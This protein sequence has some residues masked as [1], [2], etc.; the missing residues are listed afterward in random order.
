[1]R[2]KRIAC[3]ACIGWP[4]KEPPPERSNDTISTLDL[5]SES[6]HGWL[7][8]RHIYLLDP[9]KEEPFH[10]CPKC[11]RRLVEEDENLPE[12]LRRY[13]VFH[14]EKHEEEK[15]RSGDYTAP[16]GE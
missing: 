2:E 4:L 1:M 16:K 7:Q 8:T 9:D 5:L 3:D 12:E 11:Q 15:R 10:I 14:L 6:H 13:F